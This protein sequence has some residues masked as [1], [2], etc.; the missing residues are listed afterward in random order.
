M[1][2]RSHC[3][4]LENK[5]LPTTRRDTFSNS[6]R[7]LQHVHRHRRRRRNRDAEHR[8]GGGRVSGDRVVRGRH[9]AA[10]V[11]PARRPR[12]SRDT[13]GH[14][15]RAVVRQERGAVRDE[16]ADV[17]VPVRGVR[18]ARRVQPPVHGIHVR[19]LRRVQGDAEPR[20]VRGQ[21]IPVL[22]AI[23]SREN[24]AVRRLPDPDRRVRGH[25]RP[26]AGSDDVE[27]NGHNSGVLAHRADT[28]NVYVLCTPRAKTNTT[29]PDVDLEVRSA[30]A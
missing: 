18:Q 19:A 10:P 15:G 25:G 16:H 14:Q 17:L 20:G 23:S 29:R 6:K 26:D 1:T 7:K 9:S 2:F 28:G 21:A 4:A 11:L 5:L 27:R 13:A 8:A 22:G 3:R 24:R 12:G 30:A